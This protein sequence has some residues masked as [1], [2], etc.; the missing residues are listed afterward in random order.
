MISQNR[1]TPQTAKRGESTDGTRSKRLPTL[2]SSRHLTALERESQ[3]PFLGKINFNE[4]PVQKGPV[5]VTRK[6]E[7][8]QFKFEIQTSE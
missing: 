6:S 5:G 8:H 7:R 3:E 2:P 4:L 1:A